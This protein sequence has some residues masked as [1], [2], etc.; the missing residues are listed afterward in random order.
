MKRKTSKSE[1]ID[2]MQVLRKCWE[3]VDEIIFTTWSLE[4]DSISRL[5]IPNITICC[6]SKDTQSLLSPNDPNIDIKMFHHFYMGPVSY[7]Y[8]DITVRQKISF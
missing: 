1:G 4:N 2:L 6:D 3:I 8:S 7:L 5:P